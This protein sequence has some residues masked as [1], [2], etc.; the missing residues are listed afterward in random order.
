MEVLINP[1][2]IGLACGTITY[3]YL[4]YGS[5]DLNLTKK[6]KRQIKQ[7]LISLVVAIIGWFVAYG[8]FDSQT[9]TPSNTEYK[10]IKDSKDLSATEPVDFY[11]VSSKLPEIML[12]MN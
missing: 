2:V 10:F 3:Y 4:S 12:E 5:K 11:P 9:S 7:L 6:R 8:Y 1:V